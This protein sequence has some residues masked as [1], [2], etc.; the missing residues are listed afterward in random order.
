MSD[1]PSRP[2]PTL[3][4][5]TKLEE[6]FVAPLTA[7]R[8]ALEIIRDFP[9]LPS[10]ER[11]RFLETA[12]RGCA[13]LEQGI[14]DLARSVYAAGQKA[15]TDAPADVASKG[16]AARIHILQD[17]DVVEI[18]FSDFAFDSSKVVNDFYDVIEAQIDR[19]GRDWY[20]LVNYG[21]CSVWPEAWVA[22]AHRGKRIN[23][24]HSLGTVRYAHRGENG[25]AKDFRSDSYDPNLFDSRD[26]ALAKIAEMKRA[27]Q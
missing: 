27:R 15:Q 19:T 4:L 23:A 1:D 8:G 2:T 13:Q 25:E 5:S 9:D 11:G 14:D 17:L 16:Y 3:A 20:F 10:S 24:S 12:L 22:F 7:L 21:D 26:A 18:D 6:D